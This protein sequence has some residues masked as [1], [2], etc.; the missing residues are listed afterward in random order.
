MPSGLILSSP[1]L[2]TTPLPYE[3]AHFYGDR[4]GCGRFGDPI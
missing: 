4:R 1:D 3:T 2:L